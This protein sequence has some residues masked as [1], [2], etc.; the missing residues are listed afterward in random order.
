MRA[1]ILP[2]LARTGIFHIGIQHRAMPQSIHHRRYAAVQAHLKSLREGNRF[3]QT[4]LAEVLGVNQS[5]VSKVERGERYVD[6]LLYLDW[7]RAC[8]VS[9]KKAIAALENTGA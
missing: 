6:I 1:G 5:Y 9:P 2:V 3:T 7:C 4:E 8:E